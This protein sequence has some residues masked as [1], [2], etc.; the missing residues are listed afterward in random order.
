M[1]ELNTSIIIV[2]WNGLKH[3]KVCFN[4]IFTQSYKDFEI[5]FVDNGST[6]GSVSFVRENFSAVKIIKLEKNYGFAEGNNIGIREALKN[7]EIRYIIALNNDTEVTPDWL[8][9]LIQTT[10]SDDT[11]GAVASKTLFFNQR[12]IID[13]A[14]DFLLH[15]TFK[16]IARGYQERDNVQYGKIEE[17]FS[18]RAAACLYKREM[19]E[20]IKMNN[21][22]FDSKYFVYI[23]DTDLSIRARLNGWKIVYNPRAVVYHKVATTSSQIAHEFRR[24]YSGRN[25]IFTAIKNYPIRFWLTALKGRESVDADYKISTVKSI[26]IYIKIFFST[27]LSLPR[28]ISQRKCIQK[29]KKISTS[30]I[31]G[32]IN[33]FSIKK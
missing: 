19:L 12:D 1:K 17:C 15:N 30:E 3:L 2:N 21:D 4:S 18:A 32:W 23:E 29:N 14:G 31:Y 27:L 20:D 11:I 28:L 6:D 5:I 26:I 22:F 24:Y 25:R 13:S 10:K 33:R 16:V 9:N 7:K 8:E